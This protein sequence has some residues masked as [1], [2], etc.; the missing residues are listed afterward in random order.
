MNIP[1]FIN[2]MTMLNE[3]FRDAVGKAEAT[4]AVGVEE[5]ILSLTTNDAR[6]TTSAYEDSEMSDRKHT[7]SSH[8]KFRD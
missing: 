5:A 1:E 8:N 3:N 6:A 2:R 7:V 4:Y